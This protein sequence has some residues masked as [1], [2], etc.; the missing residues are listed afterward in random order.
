MRGNAVN[1]QQ[2]RLRRQQT[3]VNGE[4]GMFKVEN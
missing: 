4:R 2:R 3:T 1:G